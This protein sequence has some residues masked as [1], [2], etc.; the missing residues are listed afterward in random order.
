MK[1]RLTTKFCSRGCVAVT[2]WNDTPRSVT[3]SFGLHTF[4]SRDGAAE[5]CSGGFLSFC[6]WAVSP[7]VFDVGVGLRGLRELVGSP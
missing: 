3:V 1:Q 4:W 5:L 2:L 7:G 6:V